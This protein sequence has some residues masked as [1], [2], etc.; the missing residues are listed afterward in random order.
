[1][2]FITLQLVIF[3]AIV[4]VLAIGKGIYDQ[5]SLIV[6]DVNLMTN[7]TKSGTTIIYSAPDVITKKRV[8][9]AKLQSERREWIDID[10]LKVTRWV[11][12]KPSR[13]DG[14]LIDA[15]LS[16]E[17]AR[18][19][20][21]PGM[22]AKRIAGA[23]LANFKKG[24][25]AQG[26]STITE[27]LAV[28][29]YLKR[30]K[31]F[32]RRLQ[33]ALLALQLERRFTKDEILEMYLNEIYYGN[34][35]DGC[36]AAARTYFNKSAANLTIA[37]A[38]MLAGLPQQPTRLDPFEHFDR[39]KKRQEIVLKEMLQNQRI[40]YTQFVQAKRDSSLKEKI[41]AS[42][43]R[44]VD[45]RNNKERWT[46]PYFVSY[47]KQFLAKNYNINDELLSK[48][49]YRVYT[50]LD[51]RMQQI[52]E[53][54][55]TRQLR[56]LG[57][58]KLQAALVCV[59][60]WT[61]GVMA[62]VGGRD[63]YDTKNG[64]QF[65]RAVQAKRQPG[66]TF[67]PY[68]YATAMEQG[69]TPNTLVQDSPLR[70]LNG[71]EVKRGGHE[72]KNYDF[73]HRGFLPMY[74]AIGISNNVAATRVLMKTGIQNVIEKSHLLGIKSHLVPVPT[75]ALGTS[76][77]SLLENTSAFGVFATRG[78][79]AEETP[80]DHID[81]SAGETIIETEKPVRGARVLSEEAGNKMWE[82]LRYV[83]TNGTGENAAISGVD[84]IGKT[85]TTSSNK[86][87][88][89]MGA[90]KQL[91]TGVW[92]GYDRPRELYGSSGGKWSAPLWRTFMV[93][94]LEVFRKRNIM[95]SMIEDA[96]ATS[97]ARSAAEQSKKFIS[98][99]ICD[100]SGQL[101]IGGC[102]RT[103]T[104]QFST[105]AGDIP[106]LTCTIP[107]H[108]TRT[109]QQTST[110]PQPGD[111]AYDEPARNAEAA[112]GDV[113]SDSNANPN[114][115]SADSQTPLSDEPVITGQ[116]D[117]PTDNYTAPVD[118]V[119]PTNDEGATSNVDPAPDTNTDALIEEP[120]RQ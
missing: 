100:E 83:V 79:R 50:T 1:M 109:V 110:R 12:K 2:F 119:P 104:E 15:T 117:T 94:A 76:E 28:N 43:A 106:T 19:R 107:A 30:N 32:S 80:I 97:Q 101:A 115:G 36:E 114:I 10:K 20:E 21:H 17:D 48:S 22:D 68:V 78:L 72:I 74:K 84:V 95:E 92:I 91:S 89:F 73:R 111:I 118:I 49:G 35:A 41:A 38:A 13:V 37:E 7:R 3:C 23:A 5:L 88:W 31:E 108:L 120:A 90:T 24:R 65:N 42:R 62:M 18:F 40:N 66:S 81:N 16:I 9:L 57:G 75:L 63:Y 98:R 102:N 14:R 77:I 82:M 96:R 11:N 6:P 64:G 112:T 67:K 56:R 103:H 69:M 33:T 39:A 45:E 26:G 47:V 27:Q 86:D 105:G 4:V 60:P 59:D 34:R 58:G 46:A 55:V 61:G 70:V 71:R 52:A 116:A 54:T 113:A 99:R 51:P 53:K 29:I 85:G 87:V 93:Q 44:F 8:I 25:T